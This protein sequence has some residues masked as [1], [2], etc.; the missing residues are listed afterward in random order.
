MPL[1][2][3]LCAP[4]ST[5]DKRLDGRA[6]DVD[7]VLR[8]GQRGRGGLAV[9]AQPH[10]FGVLRA[11]TFLHD[12]GVDAAR[13][14]E[15]GDLLEEV[16]LADEEEGQARR[17]GV[18]VHAGLLHLLH[19]GDQVAHREGHFMQRR[20]A[21][22]AD[23]VT[24]DVDRV[25][26]LHVLG[27]VGDAVAHDAHAGRDREHVFLL[28]HVFLQDVGLDGARQLVQVVAALPGQRHVHG[29]QDP[30]RWVDGQRNADLLEVDAFEQRF[31]V[32]QRVDGHAFAADLALAHRVIAVVAHQGGHVEVGRQARLALADQVLE[33]LV[34]VLT[35][36][37]AGDLAHR[38]VAAAVHGGI[39]PARERVLAGQPDLFERCVR[40]VGRRVGALDRKAAEGVELRLLLL[41]LGQ[42]GGHF[43]GL[44]GLDLVHDGLQLGGGGLG[45]HRLSSRLMPSSNC[46]AA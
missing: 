29:Q 42:E 26:A 5:A 37:E 34:G 27:A 15:L 7:L 17:E 12:L 40:Q 4:P 21:R 1:V 36:A 31:H 13:G 20:R 8:L 28:R 16:G 33:A 46:S 24:R 43:G 22:L 25:V 9:K 30:G 18:H 11:E 32:G 35:G 41:L 45:V 3:R 38:P 39:G 19:I 14:A 44:P 2:C 10:A 23:V 6:H